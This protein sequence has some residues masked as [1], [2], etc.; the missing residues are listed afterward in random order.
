MKILLALSLTLLRT[1]L[2]VVIG[3]LAL[4][5]FIDQGESPLG[6]LSDFDRLGDLESLLAI[7]FF[8]LAGYYVAATDAPLRIVRLFRA[9]FGWTG[10]GGSLATIGSSSFLTAFTGASG[11]TIVALG[12][13]LRPILDRDGLKERDALG[14]ITA[15]GSVGLLFAPSLPLIIFAIIAAQSGSHSSVTVENMF[16]AGILPGISIIVLLSIF[17]FFRVKKSIQKFELKELMN[18]MKAAFGEILI[19]V[20]I[21]FGIFGKKVFGYWPSELSLAPT[22]ISVVILMYVVF[23]GFLRKELTFR[24]FL[25]QGM[26]ALSLVGAILMILGMSL[27]LTNYIVDQGIPEMLVDFVGEH[28]SE[29][30]YFLMALN[31]LLL[32]AGCLMDIFSALII[33]V[34]LIVP[35]AEQVGIHPVHMGIIFLTN[36]EIGYLTPPVGLNLFFSFFI[37]SFSMPLASNLKTLKAMTTSITPSVRSSRLAGPWLR[38][39]RP[40]PR[41]AS[42]MKSMPPGA[43]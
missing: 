21:F 11:V 38:A 28:L 29:K 30:I 33:L 42:G 10:I 25:E 19:P 13:I 41:L 43:I 3:F 40:I 16:R 17:M 37:C 7:P 8:T 24:K 9:A 26:R 34:P 6:L 35:A 39:F 14:L 1:P 22:E 18:S 15:C 23:V 2:F 31:I 5:L 12:G 20:I 4:L 32:L 27:Y 36:L